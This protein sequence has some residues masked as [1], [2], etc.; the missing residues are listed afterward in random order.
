M[1]AVLFPLQA[2]SAGDASLRDDDLRE[3]TGQEGFDGRITIPLDEHINSMS[4]MNGIFQL[5]GVDIKGSLIMNRPRVD[6][7]LADEMTNLT[8]PGDGSISFGLK[9]MEFMGLG[10]QDI[11]TTINIERLT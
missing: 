10:S 6:A 4:A 3:V 9:A 11:D 1:T 2:S 5:D 8:L 7:G